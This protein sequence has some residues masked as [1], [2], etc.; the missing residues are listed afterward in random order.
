MG[1]IKDKFIQKG[2]LSGGKCQV[3]GYDASEEKYGIGEFV[4]E[5]TPV[6]WFRGDDELTGCWCK[7]CYK[8]LENKEK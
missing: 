8:Q 2:G 7:K 5:W 6:S 1:K 4:K 3:C